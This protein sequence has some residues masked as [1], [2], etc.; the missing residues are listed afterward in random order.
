[1]DVPHELTLAILDPS[2]SVGNR[3]VSHLGIGA[4]NWL[5]TKL[6][7]IPIWRQA[8]LSL[9]LSLVE[10]K[11][12]RRK[13]RRRAAKAPANAAMKV[14]SALLAVAISIASLSAYSKLIPLRPF[15]LDRGITL[16]GAEVPQGTY[17]LSIDTQG[18]SVI[19][20]LLKEGKFVASGRGTWVKHGVRYNQD[21]VLLR[22]NSD[23][24]RSLVEI[25][26]SGLAKTI[27]FD[28]VTQVLHVAP[29]TNQ[30]AKSGTQQMPVGN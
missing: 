20:T 2:F 25:R 24:S 15:F 7:P 11:M 27:V 17:S 1:M 13:E 30:A 8:N 21:A 10:G 26:L 6:E 19:V 23:G 18:S 12:C 29:G 22:V 4:P 3:V 9:V 16:N 14:R 5:P 28:D